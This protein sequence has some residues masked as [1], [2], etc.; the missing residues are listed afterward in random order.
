VKD[1][2][3]LDVLIDD[4]DMLRLLVYV[5]HLGWTLWFIIEDYYLVVYQSIR[6][7]VENLVI[8]YK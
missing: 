7:I 3:V 1:I 8:G 6:S 4:W 5:L 2:V